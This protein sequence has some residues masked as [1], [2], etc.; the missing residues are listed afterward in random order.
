MEYRTSLKWLWQA[1]PLRRG[2]S[3]QWSVGTTTTDRFYS[4]LCVVLVVGSVLATVPFL[5]MGVNDDWSYTWVARSLAVSGHFTYNA[6]IGA[7]IGVQAWW[8]SLLIR[9]FGFSFTLVRL[10]TLPLAIGCAILL[11]RLGRSVGLNPSFAL[12]GTLSVTLSPVFIPLAA[13][14]LTDVPGFFLWLACIYC[15][16]RA[17]QTDSTSRE[18]GW[19][20][21]A[22]VTG[23]AGGTVRQ[24]VWLVPLLVLPAV[25][26]IRRRTWRTNRATVICAAALWCGSVLAIASCL[27]WFQAQPNVP[28]FPTSPGTIEDGVESLVRIAL[29]CLLLILPVLALHLTGWRKWTPFALAFGLL[30][31]G[32]L[33]GALWWFE[34]DLL[35]GNI[36]T[37]TGMLRQGTELLGAKPEIL[38]A[39]ARFLLGVAVFAGGAVTA[40]A[41]WDSLRWWRWLRLRQFAF[42]YG[43][44]CLVYTAA[45]LYRAVAYQVLFDRYLIVLLPALIVPLLWHFQRRIR[46]TPP[47]LGWVVM[48]LFALYGV[49]ATHDYLAAGR[50]RVRAATAVAATGVLR[51]HISGG[52]E[53][54]GWTEL[55]QT[56]HVLNVS[57]SADPKPAPHRYLVSPPYW[58]WAKT[59]SLDPAYMVTYSRLPGLVDAA[60][61]PIQY[62]TW[63]PPFHREVFTQKAP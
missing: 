63:L 17:V 9:L 19:M 3:L 31:S 14:F 22:A 58:F 13:S 6:W 5:E 34:D 43:P 52:M 33:L 47:A 1:G 16:V 60:F 53:Y 18:C 8:A 12:F 50:A 61:P 26:Y 29:G 55:E 51:T 27:S 10:S 41:L 48:G 56:G 28:T 54:D 45:I 40:A 30:S 57:F 20:A 62:T 38:T 36:I 42:L 7:M 35:L 39:P 4:I 23:V 59:P 21:V 2:G 32:A 49:A 15:A 25:A 11:Y 37:S 24:V 44:A 46:E